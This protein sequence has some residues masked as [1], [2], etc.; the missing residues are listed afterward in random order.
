VQEDAHELIIGYLDPTV[1]VSVDLA[2]SLCEL[3]DRNAGAE[4]QLM[5]SNESVGSSRT[6]RS[7][8]K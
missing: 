4:G 6:G 1:V 3:L 7:D 8:Q 2:E 5:R